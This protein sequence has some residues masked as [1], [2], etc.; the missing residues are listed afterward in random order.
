[1]QVAQRISPLF[2]LRGGVA[3]CA[4]VAGALALGA[5]T[6]ANYMVGLAVAGGVALLAVAVADP[7]FLAVAAFPATLLVQRAGGSGAGSSLGVSD[8]VL[9][10]A[11]VAVLPRVNWRAGGLLKSALV[12]ALGYELLTLPTVLAHPN[13]H[14]SL[15]WG[16]RLV[17]VAGALVVGWAVGASGRAA[18]AA[19]TFLAG[20]VV[21]AVVAL[22]HAVAL[23][24][25]PAQFGQYQK[26]FIGSMMWAGAVMAHLNPPWLG[27]PRRFAGMSKYICVLGLLASQSKQSMIALVFVI[28]LL[29]VMQPNV[30]RR[31]ALLV[32][33]LV[34]VVVVGII[35]L[36][37]GIARSSKFNTV[38]VRTTALGSDLKVWLL[39]PVFG[40]G[41]RWF[42]LKPFLSYIQ[43]PNILVETLADSGLLG[44]LATL[45]LLVGS[46]RLY[47]RMPAAV[48]TI[49]IALVLGRVV[50]SLFDVYWVSAGTTLPW[51]VAGLSVGVYD[52]FYRRP[53]RIKLN[54]YF[55]APGWEPSPAG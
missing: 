23:H 26:N 8:V 2:A 7:V 46:I 51:L 19:S 25:Q 9:A 45:V 29:A 4:L 17:M 15:E 36:E 14:D 39:D 33:S 49:A 11:L 32:A 38:A 6:V 42:Y 55:G 27:V 34:P 35:V 54:S 1:M 50:Q 30:R 53:R 21:L 43:P 41:M 10:L 12:P 13:V 40:Q 16:H 3:T 5:L 28:L 24:F 37:T 20:C 22:E 52:I 31:S 44:L 47:R 48:G 18:Q